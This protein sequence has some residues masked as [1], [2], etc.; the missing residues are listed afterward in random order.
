[1]DQ[2]RDVATVLLPAVP[3]QPQGAPGAEREGVAYELVREYPWEPSEEFHRRNPTG[4]TPM[5][6]L[7]EKNLTLVDSQAICEFFE[8]TAERAR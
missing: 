2:A 6:R 7:A 5:L 3:V 8:E 4:R 1:M